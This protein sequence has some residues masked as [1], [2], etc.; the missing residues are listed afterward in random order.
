MASRS[1]LIS[2]VRRSRWVEKFRGPRWIKRFEKDY[3]SQQNTRRKAVKQRARDLNK[4]ADEAV[5]AY[6][7]LKKRLDDAQAKATLLHKKA[8]EAI[9]S[10]QTVLS[11]YTNRKTRY[12]A[13]ALAARDVISASR[14][15]DNFVRN[16]VEPP[17][18]ADVFQ[19]SDDEEPPAGPYTRDGPKV[20]ANWEDN[21]SDDDDVEFRDKFYLITRP[22]D[23]PEEYLDVWAE[24]REIIEGDL[25]R[26]F[27]RKASTESTLLWMR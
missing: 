16:L 24:Y 19:S 25:K 3:F 22:P 12:T 21:M 11:Q 8:D 23:G 27:R 26:G 6:N 13:V 10:Y 1:Q 5:A 18:L 14:A 7:T 17:S 4:E 9:G 2:E 15:Y 20:F